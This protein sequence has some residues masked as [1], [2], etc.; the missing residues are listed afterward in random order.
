MSFNIEWTNADALTPSP[1]TVTKDGCHVEF[2]LDAHY[3]SDEE[4]EMVRRCIADLKDENDKLRELIT[5]LWEY[6]HI[7]TVQDGQSLHDR[8]RELGVVE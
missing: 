2:K 6:I 7:G 5:G 8:T 4:V 3:V 1:F